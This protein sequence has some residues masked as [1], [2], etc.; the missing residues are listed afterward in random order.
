MLKSMHNYNI[1]T[2]NYIWSSQYYIISSRHHKNFKSWISKV[3][4]ET[5]ITVKFTDSINRGAVE[6]PRRVIH[7]DILKELDKGKYFKRT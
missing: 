7:Q 3:G 1:C 4:G 6:I 2:S 5:K